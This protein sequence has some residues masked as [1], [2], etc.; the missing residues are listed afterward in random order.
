ML[1]VAVP[2]PEAS[3]GAGQLV[4]EKGHGIPVVLSFAATDVTKGTVVFSESRSTGNGHGHP[5]QAT[6]KCT[7]TFFEGPASVFFEGHEPPGVEPTDIIRASFE[8][9]VIIKK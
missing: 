9:Q 7:A 4:G 6:T 2:R 1:T 8:V 3:K 5:H